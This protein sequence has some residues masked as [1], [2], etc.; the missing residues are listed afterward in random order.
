MAGEGGF[1]LHKQRLLMTSSLYLVLAI[2]LY[3]FAWDIVLLLTL[4]LAGWYAYD[5][6]Q[7]YTK[8]LVEPVGK[9]VLI[10][11]CDSGF[12]L[13][14]AKA[15]RDLGFGVIAG[16][17][18]DNS[19]GAVELK[20]RPWVQKVEVL[21]LDVTNEASVA[22]FAKEVRDIVTDQG[23]WA[24]I[25]NAGINCV[26]PTELVSMEMFHRCAEV[27]LFGAIRVTKSVL[28]LI[29]HA[30]GR[31]I[32]VSSERGY[33]PWKNSAPY[34]SSKFGL[35]AFSACLRR[36]M[37]DFNVKV[38]T[39]APGEFAGATSIATQK[40]NE[41]IQE[42]LLQ[43]HASL[44][45][46]DQELAYKRETLSSIN[47]QIQTVVEKSSCRTCE[48][49]VKAYIDAVQNKQPKRVYFVH[50]TKRQWLDPLII[51]CRIRPF[52]PERI[53]Q[54]VEKVLFTVLG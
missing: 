16:C 1:D 7:D 27:N 31:V 37:A 8:E 22:A 47:E 23:L 53:V 40:N 46:Q 32:N 48:P 49:V 35:E 14:S 29:R 36:E 12:G 33:N 26:G 52:I 21:V 18:D 4:G 17:Y 5:F 6:V 51:M 9:Y 11:G 28:P 43:A 3:I 39:I 38:I 20:A 42:H 34:C 30:Q 45:L 2:V 19:P 44:S 10:T 41:Q 25:N 54:Y 24:V 13:E 50:G 15:L